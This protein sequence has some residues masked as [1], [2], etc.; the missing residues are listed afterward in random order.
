MVIGHPAPG[1]EGRDHVD[2]GQLR[3]PPQG[4]R[5]PGLDDPA[6]GVDHRAPALQDQPRRLL[7]LAQVGLGLRLVAGK[8][9][10]G[11]VAVGHPGLQ[12][13]LGD[14]DEHGSGASG[15]RDVEG[16]GD[17]LGDLAGVH[18]EPVVLGHRQGDAGRVGLLEGVASDGPPGNLSGDRHDRD[19]VHVRGRQAGHEVRRTRAGGRHAH[20]DPA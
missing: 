10:R 13:V 12:H 17:D 5:R 9:D 7:D 14:V 15:P 2:A 3:Q 18:D 11:G 4:V 1:H 19:G 8:V 20:A 6:A 16:V